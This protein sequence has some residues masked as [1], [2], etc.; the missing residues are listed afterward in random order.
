[1]DKAYGFSLLCWVSMMFF[2]SGCSR[3]PNLQTPYQDSNPL[4]GQMT[5]ANDPNSRAEKQLDGDVK[6]VDQLA[7]FKTSYRAAMTNPQASDLKQ[8]LES[9]MTYYDLQCGDYFSRIDFTR[10]HREY[11]QKQTVLVG[12]L[13][14]AI[15]GLA[16]AGSA[17]TGAT[18]AAFGFGSASFDAYNSAFLASTDVGLLRE[19]VQSARAN[20]KARILSR[21][22]VPN[23]TWPETIDSFDSAV[24]A[25]DEYFLRCHPTGIRNLLKSSIEE[26]AKRLNPENKA[27][28]TGVETTGHATTVATP[29]SDNGSAKP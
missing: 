21:I 16:D 11:V 4:K 19:L 2:V 29:V 8:F 17:V 12:S 1:M 3:F 15:L 26:K 13:T 6:F 22:M 25:L 7:R 20:D 27:A 18:G 9:G 24:S 23:K 5:A 28:S 10:A 14:S